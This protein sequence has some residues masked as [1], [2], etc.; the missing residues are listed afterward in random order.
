MDAKIVLLLVIVVL[1]GN[2]RA[3][4]GVVFNIHDKLAMATSTTTTTEHTQSGQVIRVPELS[5]PLGERRDSLG[6]CRIRF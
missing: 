5:C 4:G 1:C 2:S 6:R 3:E